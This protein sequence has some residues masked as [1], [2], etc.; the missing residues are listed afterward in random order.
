MLNYTRRG[1]PYWVRF[2]V[3]PIRNANGDIERFVS[4][5]TDS[6]E[7]HRRTQEQL[8]A[9]KKRAESAKEAKTQF[10][11]TISHETRHFSGS[12]RTC[13]ICRRSRPARWM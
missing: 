3:T 13:W 2:H 6:T 10:L 1:D 11:A 7:L 12:S 5:Q 9:A 8:C 4:I